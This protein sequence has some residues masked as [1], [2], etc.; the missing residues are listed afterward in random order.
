MDTI[1]LRLC[2]AGMTP[3]AERAINNLHEIASRL[4]DHG[5]QVEIEI[6]DILEH[7]QVA[8]DEHILATPVV[9]RKLPQPLRR[10]VGDLSELEKV[11]TG[12]GLR[13]L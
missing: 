7:P 2:I 8:E 13:G 5:Q 9:I 10:I 11:L 6:I 12:L 4:Q 3:T 1:S